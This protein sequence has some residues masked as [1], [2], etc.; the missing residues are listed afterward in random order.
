MCHQPPGE[1]VGPLIQL[2]ICD[3]PI[4]VHDGDIAAPGGG[5]LLDQ[6]MNGRVR[7]RRLKCKA[8]AT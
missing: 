5:V 3:L 2:P 7:H 8:Q 4:A 6:A 1:R